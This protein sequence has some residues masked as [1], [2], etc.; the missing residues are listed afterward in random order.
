M[1]PK[2]KAKICG[3]AKRLGGEGVHSCQMGEGKERGPRNLEQL[4][5]NHGPHFPLGWC[6]LQMLRWK[7]LEKLLLA[8]L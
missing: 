2:A 4:L 1:L 7:L 8:S 5:P 6:Y 3:K